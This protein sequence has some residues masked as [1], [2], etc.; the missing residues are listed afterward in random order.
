MNWMWDREFRSVM[1][2]GRTWNKKDKIGL[3][4]E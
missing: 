1:W 2:L 3:N 4:Y